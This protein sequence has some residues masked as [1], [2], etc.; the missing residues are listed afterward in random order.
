MLLVIITVRE[1]VFPESHCWALEECTMQGL[2][3]AGWSAEPWMQKVV[4]LPPAEFIYH[5]SANPSAPASET[6]SFILVEVLL[7][8]PKPAADKDSFW[9]GFKA[10]VE[11]RL[12][13][14]QP[15][16]VLRF[17]ELPGETVYFHRGYGEE[18]D[19][20]QSGR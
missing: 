7:T 13:T 16:V 14:M 20:Q 6:P 10:G 12:R 4:L 2:Q 1:E 19:L 5:A 3:G 8:Q 17:I 11:T 9:A 15:D 18:M